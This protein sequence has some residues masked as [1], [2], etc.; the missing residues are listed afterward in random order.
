M[1]K[2]TI[3]LEKDN[4]IWFPRIE[5]SLMLQVTVCPN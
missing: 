2:N 5:E 1:S 4:R 3:T